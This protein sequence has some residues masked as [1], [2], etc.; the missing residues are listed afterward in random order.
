MANTLAFYDT[1]TITAV[2]SF[3]VQAPG[4]DLI[5]KFWCKF[6]YSFCRLDLFISIQKI[7]LFIKWLSFQKSVSKFTL[8]RFHEIGCWIKCHKT[9]HG[10]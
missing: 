2:K 8:K 5:K 7:L 9:F 10:C 3:I 1:A 6:I 4:V